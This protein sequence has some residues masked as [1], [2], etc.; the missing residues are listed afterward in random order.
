MRKAVSKEVNQNK[1]NKQIH[2][3]ISICEESRR[4]IQH[5]RS[6]HWQKQVSQL[7]DII[8]I[9]TGIRILS[10]K[11]YSATIKITRKGE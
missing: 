3:A 6:K 2:T 8:L 4:E 11:K 10:K 1:Q 5:M 9:I 7:K